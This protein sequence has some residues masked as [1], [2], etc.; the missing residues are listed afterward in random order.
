[1]KYEISESSAL[2]NAKNFLLDVLD[3]HISI[4]TDNLKH[5]RKKVMK[6]N[7]LLQIGNCYN[8]LVSY[9]ETIKKGT[10]KELASA[11]V[12]VK[13]TSIDH[14]AQTN[15]LTNINWKAYRILTTA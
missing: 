5:I 7:D 12:M 9:L 10:Q 4:K 11:E 13:L 8:D 14:F 2:S 6:A 3:N 1:M 15:N